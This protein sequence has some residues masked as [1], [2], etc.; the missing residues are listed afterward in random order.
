MTAV[1]LPLP[2]LCPWPPHISGPRQS[3]TGPASSLKTDTVEAKKAKGCHQAL[4][5][6]VHEDLSWGGGGL[7]E[8]AACITW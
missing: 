6:E 2:S 1:T 4:H 5:A 3:V 8:A 7:L